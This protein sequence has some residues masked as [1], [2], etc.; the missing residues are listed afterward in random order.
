MLLLRLRAAACKFLPGQDGPL[1]LQAAWGLCCVGWSWLG[2]CWDAEWLCGP[3]L[4]GRME[5]RKRGAGWMAV[6]GCSW[7]RWKRLGSEHWVR[8]GAACHKA[9]GCRAGQ[10][11]ARQCVSERNKKVE[12]K[13][14]EKENRNG[15][16]Q[17]VKVR[18]K[19]MKTE[20]EDRKRESWCGVELGKV[21]RTSFANVLLAAEHASVRLCMHNYCVYIILLC[22]HNQGLHK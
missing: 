22:I 13:G 14:T 11:K 10:G 9:W 17:H 12:R 6:E 8:P 15:A 18:T 3:A 21:C 4:L 2:R 5:G 20:K 16:E 7:G 19:K 1:R